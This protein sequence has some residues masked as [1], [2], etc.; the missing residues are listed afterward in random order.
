M[1]T[2]YSDGGSR[3]NPGPCAY[4]IV[5]TDDG[6]IIFEDSKFHFMVIA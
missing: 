3:G 5:V 1:L 6:R 4:A 2:I